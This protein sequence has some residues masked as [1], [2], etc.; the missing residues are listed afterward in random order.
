MRASLRALLAGILDYAGLFPPARL[1]LEEAVR[2]YA[3]Y[4]TD[5][6]GWM[7]GRFVCPAARLV[8]LTPFQE[9]FAS[10]PPFAVSALGR[11]GKNADDLLA[12]ATTDVQA[13]A[14]FRQRHG[15]RVAIDVFE[16]LLPPEAAR[17][18][19]VAQAQMVFSAPRVAAP[20]VFYEVGFG[21]EWRQA[22][23][24]LFEMLGRLDPAWAHR[25]AG[26]KIRCGGLEASAFPSVQQVAFVLAACRNHGVPVKATAGLHH[27]LRQFD[28]A[29]HTPMHGFVNLFVAGV[30]AHVHRL[31]EAPI[32][33]IL[34]DE[35]AASFAFTD[36]SLR[37]RDLEASVEQ[38][39]W[40]REND[41][42]SFGS[43]SFDEPRDDLRALGW[44]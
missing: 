13:I 35:D 7:L 25:P 20:G 40:C 36:D 32:Q 27:P 39:A 34:A 16:W 4:R 43:C 1:P 11:G 5:P 9:L 29:L 14:A 22:L 2:N 31:S 10:G 3:R 38:I 41:V 6:D 17:P 18:L 42:T 28:A 44:L 33:A 21:P 26:I 12:N 15:E 19:P 30:L 24:F 37:W 8:E 23:G